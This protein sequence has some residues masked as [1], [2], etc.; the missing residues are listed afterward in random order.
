MTV[1]RSEVLLPIPLQGVVKPKHQQVTQLFD[2]G[3]S[4]VDSGLGSSI[5]SE[6]DSEVRSVVKTDREAGFKSPNKN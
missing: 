1:E 4:V 3:S 5:P 2:S 6:Y